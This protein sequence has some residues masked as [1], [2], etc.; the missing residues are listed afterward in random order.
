MNEKDI[1][2]LIS[3]ARL[4]IKHLG[5][6]CEILQAQYMDKDPTTR[7]AVSHCINSINNYINHIKSII[8]TITQG[9]TKSAPD[10][11]AEIVMEDTEQD[12]TGPT[13]KAGCQCFACL[14][15]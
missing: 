5:E 2:L 13:H 8:T 10:V 14:M 15:K 12:N 9:H 7:T 6:T 3:A 11:N 1:L 4:G